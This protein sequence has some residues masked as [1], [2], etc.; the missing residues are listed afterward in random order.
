MNKDR[1]VAENYIPGDDPWAELEDAL[2]RIEVSLDAFVAREMVERELV[3]DAGAALATLVEWYKTAVEL[4]ATGV[5]DPDD[6]D[7]VGGSVQT[8]PHLDDQ[9]E[10][11]VNAEFAG[12]LHGMAS[13]FVVVAE[14]TH[15]VGEPRYRDSILPVVAPDGH[16][17][18]VAFL[19]NH[20]VVE[21]A[22]AA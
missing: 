9:A 8:Q 1:T 19:S 2:D 3:E 22:L 7:P 14:E 15:P 21:V 16:V 6:D 10:A 11:E 13:A 4:W 5:F 12:R 18:G 20:E 17:Q